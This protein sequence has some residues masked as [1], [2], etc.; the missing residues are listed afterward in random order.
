MNFDLILA[1]SSLNPAF[2]MVKLLTKF[3]NQEK[4]AIPYFYY[5][6]EKTKQETEIKRYGTNLEYRT[7]I[8]S[9][10]VNHTI[11]EPSL[12]ITGIIS[13]PK[14]EKSQMLPKKTIA[15][16]QMY[17]V[18][19]QNFQEIIN[20]LQQWLKFIVPPQLKTEL[21][22]HEAY[23][24]C[25]FPLQNTYTQK[26]IALLAAAFKAPLE[27]KQKERCLKMIEVIQTAV[28]P[29]IIS[30]PLATTTSNIGNA[31]EH[32]PIDT[33]KKSFEF[34]MAFFGN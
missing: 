4:I 22:I 25:K 8:K 28:C 1:S 33:V 24:P 18:N 32:L 34:C 6:I 15:N 20:G 23:N 12:E 14:F 16:L 11:L 7:I 30:L 9:T 26:A 5:N 13:F 10:K 31:N 27:Y 3:Y 21:L 19:H 2:E 29:N 17:L